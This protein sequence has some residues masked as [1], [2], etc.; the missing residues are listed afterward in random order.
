MY[1]PAD[2]NTALAVTRQMMASKKEI[3]VMVAGKRPLPCWRTLKQ[4]EEDLREGINIWDFA[5]EDD[6]HMVFSAVGDY[7]TKETLAALNVIHK[8]IPK[9]RL[10]FVNI[11]SLSALGMGH[12]GCQILRHDIDYYFTE[13]KPVLINFHGYPQT[14][15]QI[16]FDYGVSSN[17]FSIHGYE[18]SGS[19]TTPFDMMVR[20]RVDRFS[21]AIEAFAAAEAQGLITVAKKNKLVKKYEEELSDHRAFIVEHGTDP[22]EIT[23]WK[24]H[25]HS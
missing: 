16:L 20:N 12:T 25:S 19:T 23:D 5:S 3:N 9:M 17:R 21:L 10:R 7:L 4:A 18:E 1:F 24:W 13:D 22:T 11:T 15:K 2:A 14:M 6:P 8:E